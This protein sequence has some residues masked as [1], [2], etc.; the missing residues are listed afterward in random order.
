[1]YFCTVGSVFNMLAS[2]LLVKESGLQTE[3]W[4][5]LMKGADSKHL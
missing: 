1:M 4:H 5:V 3:M 2:F